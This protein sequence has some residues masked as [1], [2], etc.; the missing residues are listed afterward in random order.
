[1]NLPR[2]V[3]KKIRERKQL[4]ALKCHSFVLTRRDVAHQSGQLTGAPSNVLSLSHE[5][6]F[7]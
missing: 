7:N 5:R 2:D 4:L 6:V 3:Q 1:M